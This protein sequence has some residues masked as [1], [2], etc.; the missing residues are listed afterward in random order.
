[1]EGGMGKGELLVGWGIGMRQ[2][3]C[4]SELQAACLRACGKE[5]LDDPLLGGGPPPPKQLTLFEMLA[6]F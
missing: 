4:D 2:L 1:M 5:P 6:A 3:R